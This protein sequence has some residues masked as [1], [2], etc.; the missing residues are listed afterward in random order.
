MTQNPSS[1]V[2]NRVAE[3]LVL[4]LMPTFA[5]YGARNVCQTSAVIANAGLTGSRLRQVSVSRLIA[6]LAAHTVRRASSYVRVLNA[7]WQL[8]LT[9]AEP[10]LSELIIVLIYRKSFQSKTSLVCAS[11]DLSC[12]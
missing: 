6:N 9:S 11:V 10:M 1:I 5:P 3:S 4:I 12:S 7:Y 2:S 8:S